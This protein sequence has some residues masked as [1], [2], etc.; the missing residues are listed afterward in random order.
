LQRNGAA[1]V[2]ELCGLS[3]GFDQILFVSFDIDR[4][5]ALYLTVITGNLR[6]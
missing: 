4:L 3:G 6:G 5:L 2:K 1:A